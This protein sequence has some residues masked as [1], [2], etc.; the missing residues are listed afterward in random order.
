MTLPTGSSTLVL[1]ER[2]KKIALP[3]SMQSKR[4]VL[5]K[6]FSSFIVSADS[7]ETYEKLLIQR[8][9]SKNLDA[10]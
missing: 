2:A 1:A 3:F 6:G 5:A 9:N 4:F 7:E 10:I 8:T